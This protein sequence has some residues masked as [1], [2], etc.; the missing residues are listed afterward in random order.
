MWVRCHY[1]LQFRVSGGKE[2]R[3]GAADSQQ[4]LWF[5]SGVRTVRCEDLTPSEILVS[6]NS[7]AHE[8]RFM[9]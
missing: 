9:K 2:G 7:F 8:T 3:P 6:R 5:V 1:G 4:E